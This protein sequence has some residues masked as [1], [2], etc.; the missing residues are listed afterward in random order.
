[1]IF[2]STLLGADDD[3]TMLHHINTTE[4][5]MYE[6]GKFSKSRSTGVFGDDAEKTGVLGGLND[7]LQQ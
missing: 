2:P 5:L 7:C 4:Y 6:S 3:Y 1:M